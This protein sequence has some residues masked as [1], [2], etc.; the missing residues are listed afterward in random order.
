MVYNTINRKQD[1]ESEGIRA[2]NSED[3]VLN[4]QHTNKSSIKIIITIIITCDR[5]R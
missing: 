3:N 1:V 4:F 5:K 2:H